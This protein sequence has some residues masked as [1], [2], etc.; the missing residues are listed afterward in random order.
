MTYDD[1]A[2]VSLLSYPE[3]RDRLI[4]LDGA[5]KTYAMTGWRLG[6]SVWPAPLYQA[7][8]KPALNFFSRPN[9]ATQWAGIAALTGPQ[10]DVRAM[11]AAFDRRRRLVV[12]GLNRL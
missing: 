10:D 8:R 7:A 3:V 2:H 12:E 11:M 4:H 9:P 5:S 6:W 1:E